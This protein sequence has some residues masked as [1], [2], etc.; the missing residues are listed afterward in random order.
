MV[1]MRHI[2]IIAIHE[3][4]KARMVDIVIAVSIFRRAARRIN[5]IG[6]FD[7][8]NIGLAAG[9]SGQARMEI[10]QIIAQDGR[11]IASR[12]DRNK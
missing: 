10:G 2:A 7:S 4:K 6:P 9:Q 1:V 11:R 8:I 3:I 12:I 5:L